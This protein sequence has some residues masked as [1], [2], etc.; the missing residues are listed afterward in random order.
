[1]TLKLCKDCKWCK[2]EWIFFFSRDKW[3]YAKCLRI[4][5]EPNDV[6]QVDG[7]SKKSRLPYCTIERKSYGECGPDAKLFES[8]R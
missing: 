6:C 1:M 8:K 7:F 4:S 5:P 3:E 2:P